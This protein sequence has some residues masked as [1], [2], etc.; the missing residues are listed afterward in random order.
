MRKQAVDET[1]SVLFQLKMQ[2][3]H[4]IKGVYELE[5][6]IMEVVGLTSA[7]SFSPTVPEIPK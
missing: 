5:K 2:I 3:E 7:E 4:F 1:F 6:L